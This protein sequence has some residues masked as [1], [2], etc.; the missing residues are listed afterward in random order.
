MV[1]SSIKVDIYIPLQYNDKTDVEV[2]KFDQVFEELTDLFGGCSIDE[3]SLI[4]G[5]WI[6]PYSNE[7]MDDRLRPFQIVCDKNVNNVQ[8]L[9]NYKEKLKEVFNQLDIFM[10][11]VHV[12][13]F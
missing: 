6:D 1:L 12:H 8:I 3:N 10:F 2:E 11:Y 7:A 13:R 5:R 4:N 9:A